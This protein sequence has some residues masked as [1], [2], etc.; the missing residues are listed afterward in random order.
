[1][2]VDAM[3]PCNLTSK[4]DLFYDFPFFYM[5]FPKAFAVNI[6]RVLQILEFFKNFSFRDASVSGSSLGLLPHNF[7]TLDNSL[8]RPTFL[9]SVTSCE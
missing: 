7:K 2:M 4:L 3:A 9:H 1:M 8:N 5:T 6:L